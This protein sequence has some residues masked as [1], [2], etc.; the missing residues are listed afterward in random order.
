MLITRRK[1]EI[2]RFKI[3][4]SYGFGWQMWDTQ[5]LRGFQVFNHLLIINLGFVMPVLNKVSRTR[6]ERNTEK[7][8][9]DKD[10]LSTYF[11]TLYESFALI[12][13]RIHTARQASTKKE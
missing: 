13:N 5:T 1:V 3:L 6:R 7:P 12:L 2:V 4:Q 9:D 10:V 11:P 8:L